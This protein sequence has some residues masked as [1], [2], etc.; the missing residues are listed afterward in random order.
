[1]DERHSRRSFADDPQFLASLSALEQGLS[2]HPDNADARRAPGPH[3]DTLESLSE[4]MWSEVAAQ[5]DALAPLDPPRTSRLGS[6]VAAPILVDTPFAAP[7]DLRFLYHSNEHD[8]SLSELVASITRGEPVVVLTGE[9]GVGKTTLCRALVDHLDRRTMVSFVTAAASA[10]DLLKRLLVDF[11]VISSD[12]TARQLESASRADLSRALGEFFSSLTVLQA[13]AL[14]I[15]DDAHAL[16]PQV[17]AEL[18]AMCESDGHRRLLQ[19]LLVGEPQLRRV[20]R[21]GDVRPIERRV[22]FRVE[23]GS[24]RREEIHAY[25]PHR[26]AVA[27]RADQVRFDEGALRYVFSVSRGVPGA[28]NSI[29]DRALTSALQTASGRIDAAAV[30]EAAESVGFRAELGS[31]W[32]GRAAVTVFLIVMLIAGA[33][34]AGWVFREPLNRALARWRGVDLSTSSTPK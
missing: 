29:C 16:T 24:L 11:G 19:M 7:P 6:V 5:W 22:A 31:S 4:A 28:V 18:A 33:V 25:V 14:V 23:L 20:L 3:P 15:V 9:R 1:M 21:R 26:L 10:D 13:S 34:G 12:E 17:W 30:R 32:H 2:Y 27:G 8:R